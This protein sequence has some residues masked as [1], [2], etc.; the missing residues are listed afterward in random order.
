[1]VDIGPDD[2]EIVAGLI[3]YRGEG[4]DRTALYSPLPGLPAVP[5]DRRAANGD[6]VDPTRWTRPSGGLVIY[7]GR[8]STLV[9]RALTYEPLR[10]EPGVLSLRHVAGSGFD[11]VEQR[12][13]GMVDIYGSALRHVTFSTS[14][15]DASEPLAIEING[16]AVSQLWIGDRIT[17]IIK[18]VDCLAVHLWNG[19][20]DMDATIDDST[21]HGAVGFAVTNG[22]A[23][24]GTER[25]LSIAEA[26][27]DC[28]VRQRA[29]AMDYRRDP[30]RDERLRIVELNRAVEGPDGGG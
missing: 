26:D 29:Q 21:F 3:H 18:L 10:D 12:S 11:V 14:E 6:T 25:G 5:W 8:V 28:D 16:S 20:A 7:G 13:A 15:I 27:P 19:S 9:T 23:L 17:G 4:T 30:A 2:G 1:M 24:V 22:T